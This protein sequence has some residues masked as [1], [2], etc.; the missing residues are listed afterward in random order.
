MHNWARTGLWP[1]CFRCP[2]LHQGAVQK[3]DPSI[4]LVLALTFSLLLLSWFS[5]LNWQCSSHFF[6]INFLLNLLFQFCCTVRCVP[7][8]EDIRSSFY[9]S[10][11]LYNLQLCEYENMIL[12]ENKNAAL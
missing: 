5:K 9:Y 8:Q 12:V 3:A 2:F 6:I 7:V 10:N 1:S 11:N 4:S